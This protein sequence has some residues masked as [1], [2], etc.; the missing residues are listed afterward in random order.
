MVPTCGYRGARPVSA[1]KP[2]PMHDVADPERFVGS[3]LAACGLLLTDDQR[4]ELHAE[5]MLILVELS[6]AFDGRGRFS[7]YAARYLRGRL[8]RAWHRTNEHHVERGQNGKRTWEYLPEAISLQGLVEQRSSRVQ[9]ADVGAGEGG[10]NGAGSHNGTTDDRIYSASAEDPDNRLLHLRGMTR[11][12][13]HGTLMHA[14]SSLIRSLRAALVPT[15]A[16][17]ADETVKVALLRGLDMP[18]DEI[19][20]RL[21]LTDFEVRCALFRLERIGLDLA[22]Q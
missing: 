15:L 11:I 19:A 9:D 8:M 5:G 14:S 20:E 6:V 12:E 22:E 1:V 4:E 17:E 18:R 7:G 10:S 13:F 2:K 21:G 3:Q 16:R